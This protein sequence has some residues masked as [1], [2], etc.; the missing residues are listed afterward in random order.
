MVVARA[1][2]PDR[3]PRAQ[4]AQKTHRTRGDL[5]KLTPNGECAFDET[6]PASTTG[7]RGDATAAPGLRAANRQSEP[8]WPSAAGAAVTFYCYVADRGAVLFIIRGPRRLLTAPAARAG[9]C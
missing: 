8:P 7:E 6:A 2:A 4:A 3:R 1:V 5:T 9:A